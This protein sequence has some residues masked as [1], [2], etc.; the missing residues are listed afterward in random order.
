M[1][2]LTYS[3]P[4]AS[5]LKPVRVKGLIPPIGAQVSFT[6]HQDQAPFYHRQKWTVGDIQV[7]VSVAFDN[8]HNNM[9]AEIHLAH[10]VKDR[11]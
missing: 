2:D 8:T 3:F 6:F 5:N 11:D 4:P 7:G 10:A 9:Y 1:M